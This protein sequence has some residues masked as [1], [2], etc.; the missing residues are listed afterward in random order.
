[1]IMLQAI[2]IVSIY[3]NNSYMEQSTKDLY[4]ENGDSIF[5]FTGLKFKIIIIQE[6]NSLN[7]KHI[8]RFIFQRTV[9]VY[10]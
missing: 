7:I 4:F 1:M 5:A 2:L 6:I 3:F 8:P 9:F 10:N